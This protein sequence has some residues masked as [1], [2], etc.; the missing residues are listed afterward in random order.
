MVYVAVPELSIVSKWS[1]SADVAAAELVKELK[2]SLPN[3]R[4][5]LVAVLDFIP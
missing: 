4:S 3:K 2:Q 1:S 5:I